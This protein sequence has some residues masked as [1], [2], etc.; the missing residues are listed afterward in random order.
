[1]TVFIAPS[2]RQQFFDSNGDPLVGGKL[3]TYKA[4]T[5]TKVA[6]YTTSVGD[7]ANSNPII[8]NASGR[9]PYGVWLTDGQSYKFTL[10][11]ATDNDPPS[12]AIFVSD[13][14]DGVNDFEAAGASQWIASGFDPT[15]ISTTQFSVTGNRTATLHVGRRLELTVSAG[16][17]YGYISASTFSSVTTVTLVM[18]AGDALD[19]GLTE[20]NYG[21]LSATSPSIPGLADAD[22]QNLGIA[23]LGADNTFGADNTHTGK[24]IMSGKAIDEAVHSEAAHAT[25]SDIW[26]GGNTC[27]LTGGVVTFTDIADA[28]QAG[29][30]R[31]VV[32]NAAH[33]ITDGS[34]LEVDGNQNYTCAAGDLLRFEAKTTS[35][36]RV[37]VMSH[38]DSAIAGKI[39]QVVN[40]QTGVSATGTT[41]IP[42]DDTIPQKTEGDEYMTLAI[43]PTRSTSKLRIDVVVYGAQ[44]ANDRLG[45]ALF[46]DTTADAIAA[47]A[48]LVDTNWDSVSTCRHTMTSATTSETTFKVRCGSQSGGTFTFNGSGSVRKLGGVGASSITITEYV[49]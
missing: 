41:A 11:P 1:M 45:T 43:T 40:T 15:F 42:Y 31:F 37:S 38:G 25:T 5:T 23:T 6:T 13:N 12:S 47:T 29:A 3:F 30:V 46:Q 28:P 14:V 34:N 8:L 48:T 10:A 49:A 7:T 44:A 32:A 18:D 20:F 21:I 2:P 27:L 16:K 17:V 33:I 35:T 26:A 9:T 39:I 19:S 24:I 22:W 4:G 36:F